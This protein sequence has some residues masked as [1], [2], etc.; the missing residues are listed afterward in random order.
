MPRVLSFAS[1]RFRSYG[2]HKSCTTTGL[3]ET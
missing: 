2:P 1:L 3:L